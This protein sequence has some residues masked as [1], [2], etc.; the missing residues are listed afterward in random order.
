MPRHHHYG[1]RE[2]AAGSPLLEECDAIGIGHPDVEQHEVRASALAD[3]PRIARALGERDLVSLVGEDL[4]EK[5]PDA[6][7]VID[8]ENLR[9]G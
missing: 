3:A 5:L 4:G 7:F 2:L 1:H 9:H 8:H 6:D